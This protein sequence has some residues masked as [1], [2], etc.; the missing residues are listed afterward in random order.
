MFHSTPC[1][2]RTTVCTFLLPLLPLTQTR[3][4][5]KERDRDRERDR[6]R[7]RP[8]AEDSRRLGI[9][10][11]MRL[12]KLRLFDAYFHHQLMRQVVFRDIFDV[13]VHHLRGR[14]GLEF[15]IWGLGFR[16]WALGLGLCL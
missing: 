15:E 13:D 10:L 5:E 12:L 2:L 3:D 8:E 11:A 16:L 14:E 4:D 1:L 7:Q 9:M 6:E